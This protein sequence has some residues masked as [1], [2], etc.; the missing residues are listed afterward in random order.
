MFHRV[1][2]VVSAQLLM[3]FATQAMAAQTAVEK[4]DKGNLIESL[5]AHD[6]V[7]GSED[8]K[9][10]TG[11]FDAYLQLS[12]PPVPV[13]RQFNLKTIW[14]GMKGWDK[15]SAWAAANPDMAKAINDASKK[16]II[17][18]PYGTDMVPATYSGMQLHVEVEIKDGKR[19][20][21]F[22]YFDA[23]EAI[24]AYATAEIYRLFE[25]G[26]VDGALELMTA[27][28][29]VLRMFCDRQFL[30]EKTH[31]IALLD[32]MLS[33]M[34]DC[35]WRY[36]EQIKPEQFR[37]I[38]MDELPYLRPDRARLLIPEGDRILAEA[39]ITEVFDSK[40]GDPKQGQFTKMFTRIQSED[41]PLTRL[42]AAKRWREISARHGGLEG[43]QERLTLIYDDWWRRWRLRDHGELLTVE[44]EFDRA[45]EM[46]YAGVLI[47]IDDIKALFSVRNNLRVAV[48]G[49]AM[50]AGLCGFKVDTGYYPNSVDNRVSGLYGTYVRRNID[51]DPYH[52]NEYLFDLD[53]FRYRLLDKRAA[54]DIGVD[55]IWL[56]AGTGLLY[57]IGEDMED[58]VGQMHAEDDSEADIII[59]PPV[60]SMLREESNRN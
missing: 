49:T 32:Q 44:S 30:K 12:K 24:E 27:N 48:Y 60:K 8:S 13:G 25:T 55:R 23:V 59:W 5:N 37:K 56:K 9:A 14:P 57:S 51:K 46:R 6:T 26:D 28:N 19:T 18:L 47:S 54:L 31:F 7:R 16:I 38:A 45:N 2:I 11:L 40:T 17:G 34:R 21:E 41:E 36:M 43:S 39:L 22:G 53:T 4:V 1:L 10:W 35:F 3:I 33:N 20:L 29:Y 50:S 52:Y 58:G 15:V 42:G